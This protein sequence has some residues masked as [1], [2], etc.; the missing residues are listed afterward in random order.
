M[1]KRGKQLA[2]ERREKRLQEISHLRKQPISPHLKYPIFYSVLFFPFFF[3]FIKEIEYNYPF[4]FEFSI[5][6]WWS[7]NTIAAVTGSSRGIG[8]EIARQLVAHGIFVVITARDAYRC[9]RAAE[10]LRDGDGLSNVDCH[11]L[12]ISDSESVAE[13]GKWVVSNFGGLDI[14]V[15]LFI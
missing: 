10:A 15:N 7:S 5:V 2:K 12:D 13:F 11:Q 1:G 14:L 3:P 9:G 4:D 8:F 6:R